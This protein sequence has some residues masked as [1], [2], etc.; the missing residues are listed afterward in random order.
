MA[1]NSKTNGIVLGGVFGLA[2]LFAINNIEALSFISDA[3]MKGTTS[4]INN[5]DWLSTVPV[6]FLSYTL[7]VIAGML[8]GLYVESR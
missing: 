5:V 2:A 7:A 3:V 8:I 6:S 1:T 4:I